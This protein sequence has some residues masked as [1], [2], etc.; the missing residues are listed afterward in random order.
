MSIPPRSPTGVSVGHVGYSEPDPGLVPAPRYP[1][2]SLRTYSSRLRQPVT[3]SKRRMTPAD[4]KDATYWIK[5]QKNNEAA[6]R[7][8]EKRRLKDLIVEGHLLALSEENA[9]LR[10]QVL[11]M[12]YSRGLQC[13]VDAGKGAASVASLLPPSLAPPPVHGHGPSLLQAGL[14]G[15]NT[16]YVGGVAKESEMHPLEGK[17]PCFSPSRCVGVFNPVFP[18]LPGPVLVSPPK[19][20][21]GGGRSAEV[22]VDVQRLMSSSDDRHLS[23]AAPAQFLPPIPTYLSPSGPLRPMSAIQ[24]PSPNWLS[25]RSNYPALSGPNDLTLSGMP[26]YPVHPGLPL[27]LPQARNQGS[28]MD[29]HMEME[30]RRRIGDARTHASHSGVHAAPGG[31]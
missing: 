26:S 13:A 8:R 6:R 7:S 21:V 31:R 12:R 24:G 2:L 20:A 23:T 30:V 3:R 5:R 19:D 9:H 22:R 17:I 28:S 14:W 1:P 10:A 29:A 18:G 25:A 16:A 27:Q 11:S 15:N 4:D